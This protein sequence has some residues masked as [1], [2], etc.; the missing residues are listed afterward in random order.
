MT[1][2]TTSASPSSPYAPASV[3]FWTAKPTT[4]GLARAL[5]DLRYSNEV[6]HPYAALV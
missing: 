2:A 3:S 5:A 6:S 1:C 4:R